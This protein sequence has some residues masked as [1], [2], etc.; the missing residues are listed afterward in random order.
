MTYGTD[1]KTLA[2]AY[3]TFANNGKFYGAK[4]I[5]R[6]ED[7]NGKTI[8][9]AKFVPDEVFREDSNYLMVSMMETSATKGTSKRLASLPFQIAGKAERLALAQQ[10]PMHSRLH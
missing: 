4:F 1:L 9:E 6:I 5:K 10:T 8:Y 2:A 3:T 7:E